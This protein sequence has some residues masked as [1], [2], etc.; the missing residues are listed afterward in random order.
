MNRKIKNRIVILGAAIIFV[1]LALG[2][3]TYFKNK[4]TK[5]IIHE[6][7]NSK[8]ISTGEI[9]AEKNSDPTPSQD[10]QNEKEHTPKTTDPQNDINIEKSPT[11]IPDDQKWALIL[12]NSTHPLTEELAIKTV[13]IG[14][15]SVDTRIAPYVNQLIA[16]AKEEGIGLGVISGYRTISR[17]KELYDE[18][19]NYWKKQGLSDEQAKEKA[20]HYVAI[21]GQSEHNSGLAIDFSSTS[22]PSANLTETFESTK[23]G[24]FVKEHAPKFGFI[25]RYPKGKEDIT[26][27]VYEPWHFRFVG[28]LAI[29]IIDS[30]LVFDEYWEKNLSLCFK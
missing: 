11:S 5:S 26:K 1:L 13:K 7:V 30:G 10:N 15:I 20:C 12:V 3:F 18:K 19:C 28:P 6:E 14:D 21:P 22:N 24:K 23:E 27:V 8:K 25:L 9:I 17:Q 29:K 2:A 4:Q 16:A